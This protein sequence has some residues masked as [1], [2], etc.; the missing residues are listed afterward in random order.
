MSQSQWTAVDNYIASRL[1]PPDAALEATLEASDAAGLPAI[2]V[3]PNQ[4]KFLNLLARMIGARNILEV[5]TL[6]GYSTIWLAR[7]L[8]AG[9]RLITLE[10]DP[11]HAQVARENI[12]RAGLADR[13]DVRLG[14]AIDTLPE[15]AQEGLP[16]FD[17]VFIDADKPSNP[18][19]FAWALK[20][21]RIG[22]VIIVDN[23]V[24]G[25]AVVDP[26]G[27]AAVQGVRRLNDL[28]AAETRVD[29]T[30]IQ[31]VGLKGYDGFVIALVVG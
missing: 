3:A 11:K 7:A 12:A 26:Q 13:V 9:G 17:L 16:P 22:S 25:G 6:G 2:N 23:V 5:G 14:K 24:R 30:A 20:L 21:A 29:A 15:I 27:D 28:I 19:Y 8:P 4:G 18:D 31:T 1:V 10:Y